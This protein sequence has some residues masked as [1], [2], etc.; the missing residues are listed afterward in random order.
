MRR[1]AAVVAAAAAAACAPNT[2]PI[3]KHPYQ[4]TPPPGTPITAQELAAAPVESAAV[5]GQAWSWI[6]FPEATCAD[7]SATGIAVSPGDGPD[8]VVF[9]DGGGAC[10]DAW[11][12]DV[13]STAV[14]RAYGPEKFATE[15]AHYFAGSLLDRQV[16]PAAVA[17]ATL[18]FV[19]YCT[20]DV[21][22]GDHVATYA[23]AG[24]PTSEWHHVG[25]ANLMAIL[26]RLAATWPAPRKLVVAGSSAG[27]FGALANYA[28]FRWYWPDPQGYLVDDSGPPLVGDAIDPA[29]RTGWYDAWH[30][31]VSLDAVCVGC[32]DDLSLAV[33]SLSS[34]H[35]SDRIAVLSHQDDLTMATFLNDPTFGTD[36][37]ALRALLDRET[38][39]AR[40]FVEAGTDHML[41][42]PYDPDAQSLAV[43]SSKG[44]LL[45]TWLE[46][47]L[48]DDPA[49]T[50]VS[51]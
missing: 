25:H 14:D 37:G 13:F 32:R 5:P 38:R 17:G 40:M 27:G 31:N 10:W 39:N 18:V 50:T 23:F 48:S 44:V 28:A 8:L 46:Q 20:G 6:P 29:R 15:I 45:T 24:I 12:C 11:S 3:E 34:D 9:L 21:H 41:L 2:T 49:W 36:V 1:L 4:G 43:Q 33:L 26:P 35:R 42:T 19:P 16:L 51:P 47:M 30:L 22:G 7:G